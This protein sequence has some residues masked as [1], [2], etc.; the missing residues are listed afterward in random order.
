MLRRSPMV[1][2]SLFG[3]VG[4]VDVTWLLLRSVMHIA[5]SYTLGFRC[6]TPYFLPR[7]IRR[8]PFFLVH[9]YG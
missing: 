5:M 6:F 2:Y 1:L 8:I 9:R 3:S 4:Y 7:P